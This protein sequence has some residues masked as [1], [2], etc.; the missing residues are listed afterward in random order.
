MIQNVSCVKFV[1]RKAHRDY[2]RIDNSQAGCWSQV[3]R[4]GGQQYV[5]LAHGCVYPG[6]VAHELLHTLGL[7]HQQS[8]YDRDGYIQILWKN[9]QPSARSN[10][11]KYSK[12]VTTNFGLPYD[13]HSIMHYGED[14]F[15]IN[16][17]ATMKSIKVII[18]TVGLLF[19]VIKIDN[20][21]LQRGIKVGT[22]H[23]LT[24]YDV[25]KVNK[26]YNCKMDP[27]PPEDDTDENE[28]DDDIEENGDDPEYDY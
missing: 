22:R 15:T 9:I 5:N 10:F 8:S 3:G 20:Y 26:M 25:A 16:G 11:N 2:I 4:E 6:I 17:Q 14:A 18:D 7:Y 21:L 12:R 24:K 13:Y 28:D 19:Q 1:R 27:E 23:R